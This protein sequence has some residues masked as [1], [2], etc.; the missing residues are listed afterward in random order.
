MIKI[1]QLTDLHVEPAGRL[2]YGKADTYARLH[3]T[4]EWLAQSAPAHDLLVVTG[5]VAC[6]GNEEAY[7]A[8]KRVFAKHEKP[9]FFAPGNHDRRAGLSRIAKQPAGLAEDD[10]SFVFDMGEVRVFVLDTLVPGRHTGRLKTSTLS[11][12]ARELASEP[13]PAI[14]FMHHAPV[15]PGMGH[16]NEKLEGAEALFELLAEYPDVRVAT[17]HLHRAMTAVKNRTVVVTAP[18]AALPIELDLTPEGGDEFRFETPGFALHFF[19]PDGW[20]T[21]FGQMAIKTDFAG[22][23]P[24]AGAV[25]PHD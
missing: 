19:G 10:L 12:L 25:N 1:L 24:F 17:G 15:F 14:L 5:D 7:A 11:W 16:M 9:V 6:D 21:H 4:G 8:V 3:E 20:V 18:P 13:T 23:F 22:P 2:A